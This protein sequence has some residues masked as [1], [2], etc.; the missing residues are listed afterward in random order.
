MTSV[1]PP[2][3]IT[4]TASTTSGTTRQ[5]Q[6]S[7]RRSLAL[8]HGAS[9]LLTRGF[10]RSSSRTRTTNAPEVTATAE[11]D[12][13]RR[14]HQQQQP[15]RATIATTV[16][17]N[18]SP[19]SETPTGTPATRTVST[20]TPSNDKNGEISLYVRIVPNIE[21]PSRSIIFDIVDRD[22]KAGAVMKI[23]RFAERFPV[24]SDHMSFKSK[25][26]SRSHCEV[27]VH[28]DG[29][30]YIRDTRSSSG[31]FLN[32]VRLS[33][34]NQE[35]PATEI[36]HGD[37]VQLGVD[38]QGG[39]EEIYR[40]VKMRFEL[41]GSRK[42]RPL[43]FS[44]TQFNNLRTLS[45]VASNHG[46]SSSLVLVDEEISVSREPKQNNEATSCN[47]TGK[48]GTIMSNNDSSCSATNNNGSNCC[49][50]ATSHQHHKNNNITSTATPAIS[51]TSSSSN[52]SSGIDELPEVDECCICL[53]ALAPFQALFVA[54]CSHSFHF[55]CI[56][57]LLQSY[58]G[59][60]CPICRAY[61]DLE[62][63][64]AIEPEEVLQK[65]GLR[66]KSFTPPPEAAFE[67]GHQQIKNNASSLPTAAAA[68]EHASSIP[69]PPPEQQ[70]QIIS[71]HENQH[72]EQQHHSTEPP[73]SVFVTNNNQIQHVDPTPVTEQG[74]S[75]NIEQSTNTTNS[76]ILI[77]NN[78]S[79]RDTTARDR[80]TVFLSD[81]MD[82]IEIPP[83]QEETWDNNEVNESSQETSSPNASVTLPT[84][85]LT[86][87]TTQQE[88]VRPSVRAPAST[89]HPERR[90]SAAN[91]MEK[92]K[93]SFFEKRKSSAV[94]SRNEQQ[95]GRKRS[96]KPRPLSYPNFLIR[97]F[98]RD[99]DDNS[100]G[101][102]DN[103]N[104]QT[105]RQSQAVPSSSSALPSPLASP[106]S[107]L[108]FNS[109]SRQSTTHLSEIQEETESIHCQQQAPHH[110][111]H[112]HQQ[113]QQQQQQQQPQ[114]MAIDT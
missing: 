91:L 43:S 64:V 89:A 87:S 24:S 40:S 97:P 42:P 102:H 111:H 16:S 23:G 15:R 81:D 103:N 9:T 65:Y 29:K 71:Q 48:L 21:N 34:A 110:H 98:S 8:S 83:V 74:S 112:H 51:S 53:Y 85:E 45:R 96:N 50:G 57:S 59:F 78:G 90:R 31:T 84:A 38:Y 52:S 2:D 30:L 13:Q 37:I 101:H 7:F 80:R 32:H 33:A 67:P 47:N 88:S 76:G 19:S 63:S 104:V 86:R 106:Q 18:N 100:N 82:V 28:Q 54:P 62:A 46:E 58:P 35:S 25:V 105:Q 79:L 114:P 49:T 27:W 55:M 108:S 60:Q 14:E 113:P 5:S 39:Q 72:Q 92:L 93:M 75:D 4:T 6:S 94:M 26:V 44:M 10:T 70:E 73:T 99:D 61:S 12:Q 1:Q 66:C 36:K 11:E 22:M 20:P 68:L 17:T 107:A 69:S 77:T 3:D 95:R 41:N 56:R 109:L